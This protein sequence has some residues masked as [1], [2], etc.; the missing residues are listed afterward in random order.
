M[1]TSAEIR[2][3]FL[4][5]F[6]DRGHTVV[7][8]SSLVP[9]HDPTLLF[10]N[11]GMVQFKD[12]FLGVEKRSYTR[13]TSAQKCMRVS[14]KHNDLEAV[15]PSP[16]H[17][18]F[19]EMLG[20]FS[21]GDYFKRRAIAY[22]WSFLTEELGLD[23]Q[24][25][26]PTV[27]LDDDEA[28]D[29]WQEIAGLPADRISRLGEKDNFWAMAETGPCGW[30]SEITWD[31]GVDAC[32]CGRPDC[33]P[34]TECERFLE[35]WNLVFMQFEAHKDGTLTPLPHP[36]VD[37]GLGLERITSVIQ[38]VDNNYDTDLF[39]PIMRR[40]QE[41][42]GHDEGTR[43]QYL[44]PYRVIADH[45][46]AIA[47]LIAD[48]VLPG[49]EGRN[50]VL[51]LVLRRAARF[52]RLLGFEGPFLTET[53]QTVIDTM[54]GHY[55]ELVERQSFI[56]QVIAQEEE[57]FLG[58]L[59]VGL[60]R[61]EEIASRLRA[62][63][64]TVIPGEEAFRLYDTYGFPLELTR[65]AAQEAGLT[66]D[67]VGFRTAMAEQRERAR[68]AQ[69]F[70]SE[71]LG[72]LY[73]QL[74]LPKTEFVGYETCSADATVIALVC[75]GETLARADEGM[76]VDVVLDRTPFYAEAGGQ[77]GDV[78]VL[79]T[80]GSRLAVNDTVK[81]IADLYVHRSKVVSGSISVGD[82]VTAEV[83][84]ERRL[85]IARNHTAT[86]LLHGALRRT[87]GD[88][89]QQAGSLVAPDRLRFDFAHLSPLSPDELRRI[90]A[91]VNE[92]IRANRAVTTQITTYDEA[93]QGGTIALFGEKYA[94]QVRMV[95]VQGFSSELCGGTHMRTTG[96][97]GSFVIISESS[98][99]SGLRRIE[100]ATGR[101]AQAYLHERL[102]VLAAI[103]SLVS[104]HPGEELERVKD[105]TEQIKQQRRE[106]HELQRGLASQEVDAI[107]NNAVEIKGARV[108]AAQVI[109]TDV[110][111]LRE[112]GDRLRDKLGSALVALGSVIDERPMVVVAVTEDLVARGLHAGKIAG[113][114]ARQMGGG[115]GG[116]PNMAQAGGKDANRLDEALDCVAELVSEALD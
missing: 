86:H 19:F 24:R 23:G 79:H 69:R 2:A 76:A 60:G 26:Y 36:S 59:S 54:G 102:D 50:Y 38:G 11:A 96:E 111:A 53:V 46:R 83:D 110:N 87:L 67:E 10:A 20:N 3:R 82:V 15:G 63:G 12:T 95:Q 94:E 28:A 112:I 84:E 5:F 98:I 115:G 13:A 101:G 90:E 7:K 91:I 104:A 113:A 22:A 4:S 109:A 68:S 39:L 35:L 107:L 89:A 88:H 81:P 33:S 92:Q 16:R 49:N 9:A 100:A 31:R 27:Y 18:T 41:L 40:T 51:R 55:R 42:L 58:T 78:G 72:E 75:D 71:S 116:R 56:R 73:R 47:F 34:A 108:L 8:S 45:S 62:E 30:T 21:F 85:D 66:V 64:N 1:L 93:L 25:L 114:A 80:G 65:D 70:S 14:G 32:N 43:R 97:I 44:A 52:G 37:T 103:A 17:H 57:R 48:G 61:L 106:I 105:L 29:L 74:D 99:G 77:V 6:E